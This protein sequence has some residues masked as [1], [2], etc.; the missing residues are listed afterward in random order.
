MFVIPSFLMSSFNVLTYNCKGL[1][2]NTKR[3]KVFNYLADKC[4]DGVCFIQ[5]T[6]STPECASKWK[7]EWGG[8]IFFSHGSSNSRGAAILF[9]KKFNMDVLKFSTDTSGRIVILEMMYNDEKYLLINLYNANNEADQLTTLGVL[10]GLLDSHDADGDCFPIFGG[11][12]NII[13]DVFLDASGGNP[14]LKKRSIAKILKINEKLDVCD[15]FR[16]RCPNLKRFTFRQKTPLRQRRLD[17]IF[18]SN[19][20]QEFVT[21]LDILPSFLS[22]HSPFMIKIDTVAS[23]ERG[24]YGWKFNSTLLSDV[25][26]VASLREYIYIMLAVHLNLIS[27]PILNGK[28]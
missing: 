12:M 10:D 8:D 25:N 7:K 28:C 24:S 27:V 6:H 15:I 23:Q 11:D 17:Y 19:N 16:V 4:R 22:D 2:D 5:E 1:Q 13:F 3:L 20:L 21:K 26:F 9:S 14:T 18:L